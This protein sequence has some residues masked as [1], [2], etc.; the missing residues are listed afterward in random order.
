MEQ[1]KI[2]MMNIYMH[3]DKTVMYHKLILSSGRLLSNLMFRYLTHEEVVSLLNWILKILNNEKAEYQRIWNF[4][5]FNILNIPTLG[6]Q[7]QSLSIF[8]WLILAILLLFIF[9]A[10]QFCWSSSML[11]HIPGT[12]SINFE[13][14]SVTPMSTEEQ[15]GSS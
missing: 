1:T 7:F 3:I 12:C 14:S 11:V 5:I 9:V 10:V 15:D 2:M 4:S 6:M 13:K 8:Q